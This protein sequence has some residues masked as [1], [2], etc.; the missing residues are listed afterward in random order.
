M[1]RTSNKAVTWQIKWFSSYTKLYH[2]VWFHVGD[3]KL[4]RKIQM[5]TSTVMLLYLIEPHKHVGGHG[6]KH[7]CGVGRQRTG[8]RIQITHSIRESSW[9]ENGFVIWHQCPTAGIVT[10]WSLMRYYPEWSLVQSN[11]IYMDCKNQH[12]QLPSTVNIFYWC[13]LCHFRMCSEVLSVETR[14]LISTI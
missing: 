6:D 10:F 12:V 5:Q 2:I 8:G 1:C 3:A 11:V 14:G 9:T 4:E 7:V 13:N